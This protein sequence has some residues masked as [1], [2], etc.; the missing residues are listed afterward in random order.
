MVSAL[1][2]GSHLNR[3]GE[4]NV[5]PNLT[6]IKLSYGYY[7]PKKLQLHALQRNPLDRFSISCGFRGVFSAMYE[8]MKNN[9]TF[10]YKVNTILGDGNVSFFSLIN[11]L[12]N[13]YS[14]EITWATSGEI[15]LKKQDY[16]DFIKCR[17]KKRIP[18]IVSLDIKYSQILPELPFPDGY[19]IRV[20]VNLD[21]LRA[22]DKLT[23]VIS[24]YDQHMIAELCFNLCTFIS[25]SRN[26]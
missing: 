8:V 5:Y 9:N 7:I 13:V 25:T 14:H 17:K 15:I 4:S 20:E 12:R 21:R 24:L 22:G 26:T 16:Q 11:L 6:D 2:L 10:K 19:G 18:L 1:A 23:S 3:F